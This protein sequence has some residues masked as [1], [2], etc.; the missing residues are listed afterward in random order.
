MMNVLVTGGAGYIG[1]IFVPMLLNRGYKVTV[2]DNF[3]FR[4]NSLLEC[5]ANPNFTMVR[6]DV[7]DLKLVKSLV[8][9]KD[10]IIPLACYTGA[11]IS[12]IDPWSATAVTRD[13]VL[14][15]LPVLQSNQRIIYPNTN[16][17]YGIGS[18]GV[19]CTEETP[20]K[21]ISLYGKLKVEVE[22]AV[23]K[24]GNAVVFRLATVFGASPQ[25]RI[26]LLVNDF[27]Y[28]AYRDGFVVLFEADFKRN[29]VHVRDVAAAFLFAIEHFD[30]MKG[31]A[32]NLG[33]DEANLSK[34][35][36]CALIQK[37]VPGFYYTEATVGEDPDKRNYIVS[38]AKLEKAGFKAQ[39]SLE[40]GVTELLKAYEILHCSEYQN[41]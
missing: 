18:E 22:K 2:L 40:N 25:M 32:Y 28:R 4:Q 13:A 7:R 8:A 21:P 27:T 37:H 14:D 16:S 19:Y 41:A 9:N 5:C 12:D 31:E 39:F 1:S 15:M 33:L 38:N 3:L 20:L 29:Y 24:R 36:L 34:R 30:A 35:E 17:G 6:G 10:L 26:D 11:P 23:L